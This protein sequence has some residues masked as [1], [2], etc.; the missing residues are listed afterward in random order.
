MLSKNPFMISNCVL[1]SQQKL[2]VLKI[3]TFKTFK[4][5]ISIKISFQSNAFGETTNKLILNFFENYMKVLTLK[6]GK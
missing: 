6:G 2:C 4:V 1:V 3:L 5:S